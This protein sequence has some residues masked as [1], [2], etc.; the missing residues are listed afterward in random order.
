MKKVI[1][2]IVLLT[3]TL[4][5]KAQDATERAILQRVGI[6]ANDEGLS[7]NDEGHIFSVN[8]SNRG[9]KT[10]PFL[11]LELP[12][13]EDISLNDNPFNGDIGALASAYLQSNPTIGPVLNVLSIENCGLTGNIGPLAGALS[14]IDYLNACDNSITDIAP[15]PDNMKCIVRLDMQQYDLTIDFTP[16][17]TTPES[18]RSQL[19]RAALY[20]PW[21][22]YFREDFGIEC[23]PNGEHNFNI[24]VGEGF[25]YWIDDQVRL[26]NGDTFNA[27]AVNGKFRLTLHFQEGDVNLSGAID[28]ADVQETVDYILAN[29]SAYAYNATAGD[30]N[31]DG[32]INV[33]D[34]VALQHRVA[35]I[36]PATVTVGQNILTI[37]DLKMPHN[38]ALLPY[39][40]TNS[41]DI[42]AMQF[43]LALPAGLSHWSNNIEPTER[44]ESDECAVCTNYLGTDNDME[45]YRILIFSPTGRNLPAGDGPVAQMRLGKDDDWTLEFGNLKI[46][47]A[48]LASSDSRNV[49]TKAT[50]GTIDFTHLPQ[51]AVTASKTEMTEGETIQ[52]T[53]TLPEA[54]A[55]PLEVTLQSEDATRFSFI[56]KQ[57][58]AAG[59]TSTT[60][61]VTAIED[62]IPLLDIANLFT[63]SAPDCDPAEVIVLLKDNDM[64]MLQLTIEPAEIN[65]LDGDG[66]ATATLRRVSNIDKKVIVELSDNSGGRLTYQQDRIVMDAGVEEMTFHL[67]AD[68]NDIIDGDSTY[69]VTAAIYVASCQCS[70]SNTQSA[71]FVQASIKVLDDDGPNGHRPTRQA[72]D[73]IVTGITAD[74]SEAEVGS[75]VMLT[76]TI[77]NEGTAPLS[78]VLVKFYRV[79]ND[80]CVCMVNTEGVVDV[81]ASQSISILTWLKSV[82]NERFYAVV[83]EEEN[84]SELRY[85]NNRSTEVNVK[86]KA[87]YTAFIDTNAKVYNKGNKV[88]FSGQLT[89]PT[90]KIQYTSVDIYIINDGVREVETVRTNE[91]GLFTY[92]WTPYALQSGRFTA[93]A[94]YPGDETNEA[95]VTFDVYGLRRA[96]NSPISYQVTIDEPYK[97][98]IMLENPGVLPLTAVRAAVISAPQGCKAEVSIPNYIAA[99]AK[100]P[101]Q[102]TIT[103]TQPS[104]EK[105]WERI[106]IVVAT[107][108]GVELPLILNY[109]AQYAQGHLKA[110]EP[111]IRTTMFKDKP[112]DYPILLTNQGKGHTGKLTLSLPKC[113]TSPMGTTL[114][115]LAP[116]DSVMLPLRFVPI[117]GMQLNVP[118]DGMFSIDCEHGVGL[119]M[120]FAVT[121]VSQEKGIL[122]VDVTDEFTYY[123]DDKPHVAGAQVVLRNPSTLTLVAQGVTDEHGIFS[124]ELPE[125]CYQLNVTADKHNS[126][127]NLIVVDPG[128]TTEKNVFLQYES[129]KVN[130]TVEEG[131]IEDEY[132]IVTTV[133]YETRVPAP[134]VLMNIVPE[135]LGLSTM[136]PG[137]TVLYHTILTN[138]GMIAALNWGVGFPS[139]EAFT[140]KPLEPH[141][142]KDIQPGQS[143]DIPVIVIRNPIPQPGSG[144]DS[145]NDDDGKHGNDGSV[146]PCGMS[147]T[148]G[149]EYECNGTQSGGASC[150]LMALKG[151][152]SE[153]SFSGDPMGGG[154]NSGGGG[155]SVVLPTGDGGSVSDCNPLVID[156]KKLADCAIQFIPYVG[157]MK[158]VVDCANN[159]QKSIDNGGEKMGTAVG[160]CVMSAVGTAFPAFGMAWNYLNCIASFCGYD[161]AVDA[162]FT[163]FFAPQRRAVFAR[164]SDI[165]PSY[166]TYFKEVAGIMLDEQLA[167]YHMCLEY[168]G[169]GDWLTKK[170]NIE[171]ARIMEE[172]VPA[173]GNYMLHVPD[174]PDEPEPIVPPTH[175]D[176]SSPLFLKDRWMT[177]HF[178]ER[179]NNTTKWLQT[180]EVSNNMIH[181]DKMMEYLNKMRDAEFEAG[182]RNYYST[183]EMF[184]TEANAFLERLSESSS[185][186]CA[187]IKLQI[188]QKMTLTRQAFHG[189]LTIENGA[190]HAAMQDVKLL[191]NVHSTDGKIAT[192]K[193]FAIDVEKLNGFEGELAL[194]AGWTLSAG[195]TGTA[196][197][198]FVPTKYAAPVRPVNYSF[199]GTLS[200]VDANTGLRVTRELYPVTLTVNPTPELDLTYFMQRDIYGDDAMTEDVVEPMVPAEF[201]VLINNKGYGDANNVKMVTEQ[202]K[203][204]ENK[205]QLLIDFE[206]L[207]SQLNGQDKVMAMGESVATEF[208]TIPAHSQSYATWELQSTL[209]G[210]FVKYNIEATHVTSHNNPDLSILDQ[211]TIHELIHGF[212]FNEKV[213]GFLCNDE[214]DPDDQPDQVYFSNATQQNV[215]IAADIQT[216]KVMDNELQYTLT[217]LPTE[218]GWTYGIVG[219]PTEGRN[220]LASV[221]RMSDKVMLPLDN[222]W[223]TD[224]TLRDG[225]EPRY[226]DMLHFIG[227]VP[228]DGETYLL[229]FEPA[230]DVVL[231]VEGYEGV[232]EEISV[233]T[234]PVQS[235]VVRF[236][237]SIDDATFTTADI[238][239]TC[240]GKHLNVEPVIISKIED[241]KFTLDISKLTLSDGYYVLTVQTADITDTEGFNGRVGKQAAWIQFTGTGIVNMPRGEG[242]EGRIYDLKGLPIAGKGRGILVVKGKKVIIK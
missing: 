236:N 175:I 90:D 102:L 226:E 58:I 142:G 106:E 171:L 191:L 139:E 61:T 134:V 83:N 181:A 64:P 212:T 104:P 15:I 39:E 137:D 38:E 77:K 81:G 10:I 132:K 194:D 152:G 114:S 232:A 60:F 149:Y 19:P 241:T 63:V 79:K 150:T 18:L 34:L 178:Y 130:W 111:E 173:V 32:S 53:V 157:S 91:H 160:D 47:N 218:Q 56:S 210:H 105:R 73:A 57:T 12:Y 205:K 153:G 16:G 88:V 122:H 221:M 80:E 94:C 125:G 215:R 140:F 180:G 35:D 76:A 48:I 68:D 135:Q 22:F 219:D 169:N 197:I 242:H 20:D 228:V 188:D 93:G 202:P 198:L 222:V 138:V 89:G 223:Q 167:Y 99:D 141:Q 170:G 33:L 96:D 120:N 231:A 136:E 165:E 113:I 121:P 155:G 183:A 67:G 225:H 62:D 224:R 117:D 119:T 193:E 151:C 108:E 1:I 46:D 131:E 51:L 110:N 133:D 101:L 146:I 71:G 177:K 186:V 123:T 65:E 6:S 13:V 42:A 27:E 11:L 230:P 92:E 4:G 199:G 124:A 207:S 143:V 24:Y 98:N 66:A 235:L 147:Q 128:V 217:V 154:P 82:G 118:L 29:N 109:Y 213:R 103:G 179:I 3:I 187:T 28:E 40:L 161:N 100:V 2:S 97:G 206:I 174:I 78:S 211:V 41:N 238:T 220:R 36:T 182:R 112:R 69:V 239:L 85:T 164:R 72:P 45:T 74:I 70:V 84:V 203:I 209:L 127:Q 163:V 17:V 216:A 43:D 126:Y 31:H 237:K 159:V 116:G 229:T 227:E 190:E 55:Q 87:P 184:A 107:N 50:A 21:N 195:A 14:Q 5:L 240:Q 75:K 200:Y 95:M 148:L 233:V 156:W 37:R 44:T 54:T 49:L 25:G 176:T 86:S 192:A 145:G 204:I 8:L 234:T 201:T 144:D 168:F 158:G 9:L 208:G 26:V 52:L 59:G 185:G 166:V 214:L 129:V 172:V 23:Y 30:V 7:I 189:T 115:G 162:I 196:T